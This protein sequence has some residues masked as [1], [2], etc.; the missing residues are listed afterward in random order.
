[1]SWLYSLVLGLT[2]INFASGTGQYRKWSLQVFVLQIL[3]QNIL[4]YNLNYPQLSVDPLEVSII[5][6]YFSN[7]LDLYWIQWMNCRNMAELLPITRK[8]QTIYQSFHQSINQLINQ[9]II[10][11][12]TRIYLIVLFHLLSIQLCFSFQ[13]AWFDGIGCKIYI[14]CIYQRVWSCKHS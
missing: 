6:L 2:L 9:S 14:L 7:W 13:I 4:L 1:M 11:S 8:Q 3:H 5:F 12:L 10:H